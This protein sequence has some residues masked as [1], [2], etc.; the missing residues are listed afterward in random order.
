[1][2]PSLEKLPKLLILWK[3]KGDLPEI[4]VRVEG[5]LGLGP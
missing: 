3:E 1:M 5:E 4:Q 2:T